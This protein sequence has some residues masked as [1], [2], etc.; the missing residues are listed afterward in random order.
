MPYGSLT[1]ARCTAE[2]EKARAAATPAWALR[3][4]CGSDAERVR[5]NDEDA[6]LAVRR[7]VEVEHVARG[8]EEEQDVDD[9]EEEVAERRASR[10]VV[11]LLTAATVTGSTALE[12][13]AAARTSTM[14]A[15]PF[16][17]AYASEC[18]S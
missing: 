18:V 10:G 7:D 14:S 15:L 13:L 17:Y 9:V 6:R 11:L 8:G 1:L 5:G 4:V 3:L 2:E 16:W 12:A